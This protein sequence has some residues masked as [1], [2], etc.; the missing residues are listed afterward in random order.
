MGQRICVPYVNNNIVTTATPASCSTG[1][2]YFVA[3]TDSCT[4]IS[5]IFSI[6]TANLQLLNP[7]LNCLALPVGQRICVP[8]L[9]TVTSS[10]TTCPN[11][12]TIFSGDTCTNIAGAFQTTIAGLQQLNPG[13]FYK[14][15]SAL[16][17]DLKSSYF[18]LCEII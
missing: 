6:T 4:S 17:W 8:F 9:N 12:Y 10:P 16:I 13:N 2:F 5:S 15:A 1:N 7:S 14:I 18:R 11:F 3:S